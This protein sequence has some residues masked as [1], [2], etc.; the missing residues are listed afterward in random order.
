M[1]R[2]QCYTRSR[3]VTTD[4]KSGSLKQCDGK[5]LINAVMLDMVLLVSAGSLVVWVAMDVR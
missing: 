2:M 4:I 5:R 3:I 1:E